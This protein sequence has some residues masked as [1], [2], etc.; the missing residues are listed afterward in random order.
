MAAA[1]VPVG[2]PG[3]SGGAPSSALVPLAVPQCDDTSDKFEH[4]K[5]SLCA[6]WLHAI[7]SSHLCV[8]VPINAL[9]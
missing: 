4:I 5:D 8:A 2:A 1:M 3:S 6:A 9:S 7:L